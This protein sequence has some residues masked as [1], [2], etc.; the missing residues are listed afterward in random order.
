MFIT[1]LVTVCIDVAVPGTCVT[2]PVVN[3][4][5]DQLTMG[6]CLGVVGLESAKEFWEQ[7]PLYH[8]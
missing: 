1:V 3:S 8:N 2:M 6:S 7:H 4:N 5:Q